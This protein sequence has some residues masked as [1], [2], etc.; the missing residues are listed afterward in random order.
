MHIRALMSTPLIDY[1][2]YNFRGIL[3]KLD[4]KTKN[5]YQY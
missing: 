4:I 2:C 5:E 1:M 3:G